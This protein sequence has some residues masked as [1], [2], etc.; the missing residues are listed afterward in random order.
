M[1]L[2]RGDGP[3]QSNR[4]ATLITK[5]HMPPAT[6]LGIRWPWPR[7]PLL[8]E[9]FGTK[10]HVCSREHTHIHRP[11]LKHSYTA[12]GS[13]ASITT[14]GE[15]GTFPTI[16]APPLA[17]LIHGDHPD[18]ILRRRSRRQYAIDYHMLTP[19][20][21]S[22]SRSHRIPLLRRRRLGSTIPRRRLRILPAPQAVRR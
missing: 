21:S 6:F 10:I 2:P 7:S 20:C 13:M 14:A 18:S 3:R 17:D 1:N 15:A 12:R 22:Y 5:W 4:W 8:S 9:A 16:P 19:Y 11:G